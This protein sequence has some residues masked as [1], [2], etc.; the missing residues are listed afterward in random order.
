MLTV[1]GE[2]MKTLC[3]ILF[4]GALTSAS[5]QTNDAARDARVWT[6]KVYR[7]SKEFLLAHG[8]KDEPGRTASDGTSKRQGGQKPMDVT[9]GAEDS[10]IEDI[11]IALFK[12]PKQMELA[13]RAT[14][15]IKAYRDGVYTTVNG[16]SVEKW[17]YIEE[18][19]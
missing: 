19:K 13:E 7:V 1:E 4:V 14:I 16:H 15:R 10:Q 9:A 18:A 11:L 12:H 17:V 2:S 5:A 8:H 6:L 3:L